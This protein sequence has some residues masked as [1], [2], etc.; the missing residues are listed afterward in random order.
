M[1]MPTVICDF[2]YY[3]REIGPLSMSEARS[4]ASRQ[5]LKGAAVRIKGGE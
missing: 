5:A 3:T 1:T 2:G 4:E